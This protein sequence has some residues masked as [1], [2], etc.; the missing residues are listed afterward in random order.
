[1][2]AAR[3]RPAGELLRVLG[4]VFG[5]AAVVGG[6]VGQGILRTP[7][8]VA[9]AVPYPTLVLLLWFAGGIIAAINAIPY[10]ELGS[11]IPHAGGPF[12][13]V[14]RAFGPTAGVTIGWADWLQSLS[15][16]GFMAVVVAEFIHRLGLLTPV[17]QALLAPSIIGIVFAINWSNT[18]LC[19]RSQSVGSAVK[20]IALL[21]LVLVLLLA[22]KSNAIPSAAAGHAGLPIALSFAAIVVALRAVQNTYDGWNNCIYFC[23]EMHAPER[24][25]PR[26]LFGGIA[27]VTALYVLVNLALLKTLPVSAMAAS[28]FPAADALGVVLGEWAD[29]A[30]TVFG[31]IS[32]AAILN[33]QVMFGPRIALAMARERVLPPQL[34]RVARGGSPRVALTVTVILS[35]LLSAS[36][37][38]EQLIALNVALGVL[39]N[40]LVAVSVLRLRRTEPSLRRPWR[41]PLYPLPILISAAI[42]AALLGALV[43]EDPV[44]SLAGTGLACLIGLAYWIAARLRPAR[45]AAA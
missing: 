13:F 22:P 8:I 21:A 39:I 19:G 1:M 2:E 23:E 41:T 11:S 5:I 43:Y 18:R 15:A 35:A 40:L 32:V 10:A 16:Q 36:G 29:V 26:A 31:V 17:P 24:C 30:L 33:L 3:H 45:P 25:V 12:V 44:R 37:T 38:Y 14:R 9:G 7:G 20:G 34:T 42:N 28:K 4:L 27:V 6:A